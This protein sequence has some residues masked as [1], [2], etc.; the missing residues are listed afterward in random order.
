MLKRS[1]TAALLFLQLG[2]YAQRK[3]ILYFDNG[4]KAVEGQWKMVYSRRENPQYL[5][6]LLETEKNYGSGTTKM[7][8]IHRDDED[9]GLFIRFEGACTVYYSNGQKRVTG[10]YKY[11]IP[12]GGFEWYNRDG[13]LA[14]KGQYTDGMPQGKW[15]YYYASG[16]KMLDATYTAF[17]Q[18]ELDSIFLKPR[19]TTDKPV[20]AEHTAAEVNNMA[21]YVFRSYLRQLASN[22]KPEGKIV[23]Y[24]EAGAKEAEMSFRNGTPDGDWIRYSD[25]K[26]LLRVTYKENVPVALYDSTQKNMMDGAGLQDLDQLSALALYADRQAREPGDKN[27][28]ALSQPDQRPEIFMTVEQMPEFPG[29]ISKYLSE[30]IKYPPEAIKNNIEG[31][32]VVRFVVTKT[33][34][35]DKVTVQRG[36]GGGC[37]EEAVRLVKTMPKWKPGKQNGMAVNVYY[38][39]PITFRLQ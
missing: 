16:K 2:S 35:I 6:Y 30:H 7:S 21:L 32:V 15:Q 29:D 19:K 4:K 24:T 22:A 17:S 37:D 8:E 23:F 25:G 38:T 3:Q 9:R 26:P 12:E 27:T 5:Q 14:V 13:I 33:G 11:G 10:N 31:R 28:A 36:I 1:T 34:D 18:H 20:T 39:L